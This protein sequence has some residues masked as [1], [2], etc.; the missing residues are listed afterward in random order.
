LFPLTPP[1][2]KALWDPFIN[3]FISELAALSGLSPIPNFFPIVP[4][5]PGTDIASDFVKILLF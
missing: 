2:K 3:A 5:A 4:V 1:K